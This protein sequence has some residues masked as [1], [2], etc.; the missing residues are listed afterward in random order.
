[1]MFSDLEIGERFTDITG[2][3]WVKVDGERAV[4]NMGVYSLFAPHDEC[5][6]I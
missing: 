2:E 1:M 6:A 3:T 5:D 4:N